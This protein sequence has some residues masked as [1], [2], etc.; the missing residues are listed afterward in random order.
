[1]IFFFFF[2]TF[3]CAK[4][5]IYNRL[6]WKC[7]LE[8][9]YDLNKRD[10]GKKEKEISNVYLLLFVYGVPVNYPFALQIFQSGSNFARKQLNRI[11]AEF[12]VLSQVI[13]EITAQQQV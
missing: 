8:R 1:M 5:T 10:G 2:L 3:H 12:N 4:S 6:L 11:F 9:V 7:A 13:P